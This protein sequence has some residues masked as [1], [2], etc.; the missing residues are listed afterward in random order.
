MKRKSNDR[1]ALLGA[2]VASARRRPPGEQKLA[3]QRRGL[4]GDDEERA[5]RERDE[6]EVLNEKGRGAAL[7]VSEMQIRKVE[8]GGGQRAA[9]VGGVWANEINIGKFE[10]S[11]RGGKR[12][13]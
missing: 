12:L 5:E 4:V 2:R 7:E 9:R 3:V 1:E 13:I 6:R 8:E 10:P 11:L